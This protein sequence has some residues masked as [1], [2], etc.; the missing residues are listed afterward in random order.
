MGF[1]T[2]NVGNHNPTKLRNL[3][4]TLEDSFEKKAIVESKPWPK[5]D[6][7]ITYADVSKIKKMLGWKPKISIKKGIQEFADWFKSEENVMKNSNKIY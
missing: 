3:I 4:S 1:E 5:S 6:A 7:K 2:L